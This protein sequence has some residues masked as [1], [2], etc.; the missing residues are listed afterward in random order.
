[1]KTFAPRLE[2]LPTAQRLLWPSLAPARELG[3][4]LYGGTAIALHLGHRISV[5]FDFFTEKPLD[6]ESLRTGLPFLAKSLTLQE[7]PNGLIVLVPAEGGESEVK[8]SFFGSIGFGRVGEPE[9]AEDGTLSVAS[10]DDLMATKVKVVLQRNEAKDYKDI[11]VMIRSGVSLA[12]GLASARVLYGPSFQPGE[13]LKA[14][15]YFEGGD[16]DTLTRE[17]RETLIQMAGEIRGLP[18]TKI[19][20]TILSA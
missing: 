14:L 13:S 18:D 16:L 6:K 11:A 2:I 3:L 7:T 12:K 20:S 9:L 4:V 10:L 8:V 5:D 15:T 19:V 1:M 17:E